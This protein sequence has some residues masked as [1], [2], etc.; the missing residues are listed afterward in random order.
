MFGCATPFFVVRS[1]AGGVLTRRPEYP[2]GG[3]VTCVGA[4]IGQLDASI[5]QLALPHLRDVF[6]SRLDEV[7]WVS[8]AYLLAFASTPPIFGRL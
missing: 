5:V 7:S 6:H 8:L 2:G 4:F 3:G 1:L